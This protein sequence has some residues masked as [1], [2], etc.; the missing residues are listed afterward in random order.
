MVVPGGVAEVPKLLLTCPRGIGGGRERDGDGS[1]E[2]MRKTYKNPCLQLCRKALR[3]LRSW[4]RRRC[5][6]ARSS[7]VVSR[8]AKLITGQTMDASLNAWTVGT[9]NAR[10]AGFGSCGYR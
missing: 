10:D 3:A 5:S 8:P 2:G 1:K 9:A 7:V 4:R 6:F